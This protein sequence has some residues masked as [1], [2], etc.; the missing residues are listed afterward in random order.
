MNRPNVIYLKEKIIEIS[1]KYQV[2]YDKYEYDIKD[3]K[4]PDLLEK[5]FI[6]LRTISKN[7]NRILTIDELCEILTT[8][9][10]SIP[11]WIEFPVYLESDTLRLTISDRFRKKTVINEWHKSNVFPPFIIKE[12]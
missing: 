6:G 1:Q 4:E 12:E 7:T 10:N 5:S 2:N 3:H 9:Y 8:R 11:L